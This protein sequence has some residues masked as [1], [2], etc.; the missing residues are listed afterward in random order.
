MFL[1]Y[2]SAGTVPKKRGK[3]N[4]ID[5]AKVNKTLG[6]TNNDSKKVSQRNAVVKWC[7]IFTDFI[8]NSKIKSN[9]TKKLATDRFFPVV[10]T[11]ASSDLKT[12][13][14]SNKSEHLNTK[15]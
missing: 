4:E 1:L 2:I 13:L 14:S 6:K 11:P 8:C 3:D 9:N 12:L 10:S 7:Y 15:I 5:L